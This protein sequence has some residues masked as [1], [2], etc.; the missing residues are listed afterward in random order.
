VL[1]KIF[2]PKR[3][4]VRV[5]WRKLYSEELHNFYHSVN[6]IWVI[7]SWNVRCAGNVPRVGEKIITCRILVRKPEGKI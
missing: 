2:G 7:K 6:I 4:E 3:D 5:Y 1:R